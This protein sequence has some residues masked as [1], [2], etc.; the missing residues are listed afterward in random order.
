MQTVN[1]GPTTP[2]FT[3]PLTFDQYDGNL[4][5]LV[6][7]KV[8][9][10][11]EVTGG[12]ATVDND[13]MTSTNVSIEFGTTL[14]LSST[15]VTL[16]DGAFQPVV[17]DVDVLANQMFAL[18]ANDLDDPTIFNDDGGPDNATLGGAIGSNMGMGFINSTFFS[19]Y[20]GSGTF[21]IIIDAD[22]AFS[23]SGGSG[24][25]G[26]FTPQIASGNLMVI[27]E[28]IPAPSSLALL[29]IGGGLMGVRR[30]R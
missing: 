27:Y 13:G 2:D 29:A 19:E 12:S 14:S 20:V 21:D 28:F 7:V 18:A 6:S 17:G 30:R 5:D 1:F 9:A 26:A 23:I 22:T 15:D 3:I 16:L 11:L 10:F 4:S 25:S 8:K 24:V